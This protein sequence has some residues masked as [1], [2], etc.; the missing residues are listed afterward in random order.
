MIKIYINNVDSEKVPGED[1]E[2]FLHLSVGL[3]SSLFALLAA[4]EKESFAGDTEREALQEELK[5]LRDK[6]CGG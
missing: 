3:Y 4:I 1:R 5:D 6:N 2:F